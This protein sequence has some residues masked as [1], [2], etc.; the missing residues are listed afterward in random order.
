MGGGYHAIHLNAAKKVVMVAADT[1]AG[2]AC[3]ADGEQLSSEQ[4][5][6]EELSFLVSGR[7]VE[8]T[9]TGSLANP[10]MGVDGIRRTLTQTVF[11]RSIGS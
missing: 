11:I 2:A 1:F 5:D 3:D 9:I 6:I 10:G 8:V 4:V 7:K